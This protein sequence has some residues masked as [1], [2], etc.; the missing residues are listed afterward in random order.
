MKANEASQ[1]APLH[2]ARP[3]GQG[4]ATPPKANPQGIWRIKSNDLVSMVLGIE[5]FNSF[6]QLPLKFVF[7]PFLCRWLR[8][9]H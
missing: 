6:H 1:I 9:L 2:R 4:I 8:T 5:V 7:F 3:E